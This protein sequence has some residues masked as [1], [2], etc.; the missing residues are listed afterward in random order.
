M[1]VNQPLLRRVGSVCAAALIA[2][3][4]LSLFNSYRVHFPNREHSMISPLND[5]QTFCVGRYQID[6]P[7]G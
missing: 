6:L 7:R 1:K 3:V 5:M 2:W 4:T